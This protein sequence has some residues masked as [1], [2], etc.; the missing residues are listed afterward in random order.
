MKRLFAL[1]LVL[2]LACALLPNTALAAAV[3]RGSKTLDLTRYGYSFIV[4]GPPEQMTE[5]D[6]LEYRAFS[7]TMAYFQRIGA[8]DT[9]S[10]DNGDSF[11]G[12]KIDLDRD[13]NYD[14]KV[15]LS[16][17]EFVSLVYAADPYSNLTGD[18]TL[19]L[20]EAD[21]SYLQEDRSVSVFYSTIC[22]SFRPSSEK[23]LGTKRL[24]VAD[25][26]VNVIVDGPPH[27]MDED[28]LSD[29]RALNRT[30]SYLIS[31]SQIECQET[32]ADDGSYGITR[33]DLDCD[34]HFDLRSVVEHGE[35]TCLSYSMDPDTNLCGNFSLNLSKSDKQY[36][37]RNTY[38][39]LYY[40]GLR[41][42]F[43]FFL[44][45]KPGKYYYEPVR[46]AYCHKTQV[47]GGTDATHF[48][49]GR[50]CTREQ[51]VTF[52]WKA[53]GAPEPETSGQIFD[54]VKPS[55]Y[56]FKAVTWAVENGI[57]SGVGDNQFGVGQPCKREQAVTFLWKACGSPPPKYA[58]NPFTDVKEGKY[59]YYAVV[60]A[61][62]NDITSGTTPTTFG[63]GNTCTR[64]QIMTFLYNAKGI[65]YEHLYY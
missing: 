51:I 37:D 45:V 35:Y 46:W 13:G 32:G 40:S 58:D 29:Y 41:F 11:G 10:L 19:R 28:T 59:Y 9:V 47:T 57:T 14:I 33:Y 63:V 3:D 48:S 16:S 25:G 17:G 8:F 36:L 30:M 15:S 5:E 50:E 54:D 31:T 1:L 56:Y 4:S 18:Y 22:F 62:M 42:E 65:L 52:L 61:A 64:G 26:S 39:S 12:E 20:N 53:A 23:D 2:A 55:K 7:T 60:W 24:N 6:E 21:K 38:T 49:P 34:G 43:P 44:D 27:E